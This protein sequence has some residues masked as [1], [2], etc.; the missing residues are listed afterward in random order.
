MAKVNKF[1]CLD[2]G[3]L[4]VYYQQKRLTSN[5]EWIYLHNYMVA[6]VTNLAQNGPT[7]CEVELKSIQS[8]LLP[9]CPL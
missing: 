5:L 1:K 6:I 3:L 2:L 7:F 9:L 4:A 8:N